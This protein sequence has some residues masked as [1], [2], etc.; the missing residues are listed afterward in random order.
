MNFEIVTDSAADVD[1]NFIAQEG[2]FVVPT[3][4]I[5]DKITYYD[6]KI[7]QQEVITR[8]K[9][10]EYATTS[11]SAPSDFEDVYS[12][13]IKTSQNKQI[14]GI[15]IS[16]KLSGLFNGAF[17]VTNS[18]EGAS[19]RLVDSLS[20]SVGTGYLV[21]LAAYLRKKQ[22]SLERTAKILERARE[23]IHIEVLIDDIK[24]LHRSGRINLK[25]Y[26]LLRLFNLKP[27][28]NIKNGLIVQ[29]GI[30]IGKKTGMRK[31]TRR[32]RKQ[33]KFENPLLIL[34]HANTPN[35][36]EQLSQLII[37]AKHSD[38]LSVQICK[39]LMAHTGPNVLGVGSAPPY[40][41]FLD[42]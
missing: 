3:F 27:I 15:H 9:N 34:G 7:S 25:Q 24:Y 29:N 32:I 37:P 21:Y 4:I 14:L 42:T 10:G 41:Y 2:I 39:T 36:L 16:S 18:L 26:S 35:D 5:F 31:I 23:L 28:L 38:L 1:P 11:Q 19:I 33:L 30:A 12:T 8:M 13:A 17:A 20:V 6:H 22:Y 40:D